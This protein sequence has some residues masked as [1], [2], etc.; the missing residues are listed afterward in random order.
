[1]VRYSLPGA[2]EILTAAQDKYPSLSELDFDL[3]REERG[4]ARAAGWLHDIGKLVT[5]TLNVQGVHVSYDNQFMQNWLSYYE[6]RGSGRWQALE[7]ERPCRYTEAMRKLKGTP[8]ERIWQNSTFEAK[9]D[10]LF[11]VRYHM[12]LGHGDSRYGFGRRL[13]RKWVTPEGKYKSKRRY[14]LLMVVVC[15]DRLGRS[16]P[17]AVESAHD[18]VRM[19]EDGAR[20]VVRYSEPQSEPAP[21]DPEEFLF[22]L[23]NKPEAGVKKAFQGKFGREVTPKELEMIQ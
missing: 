3:T 6:S 4:I 21:D 23:R 22:L 12:G 2:L 18:A 15:M 1:M 13:S 8:W 16:V 7:H 5:T 14:K 17:D 9:K 19:F 10:V 20:F 11:C